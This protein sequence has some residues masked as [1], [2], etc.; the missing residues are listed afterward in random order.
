MVSQNNNQ[1]WGSLLEMNVCLFHEE[2]GRHTHVCQGR[3][4]Y[5]NCGNGFPIGKR[6][7]SETRHLRFLRN[8]AEIIMP[9]DPVLTSLFTLIPRR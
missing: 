7:P 5:I 2:N 6:L 3:R 8:V 1:T 9:L 4:K